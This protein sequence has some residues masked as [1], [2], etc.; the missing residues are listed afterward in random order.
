MLT[1]TGE[2]LQSGKTETPNT[3][4]E[5]LEIFDQW[6]QAHLSK[7]SGIALS[8]PGR[9]DMEN[10]HIH[11]GDALLYLDG[12]N[13]KE[14]FQE[15]YGLPASVV[16]DGKAAGQAELWKGN[17]QGVDYAVSLTLGTGIGGA[18]IVDGKVVQGTDFLAGELSSLYLDIG[19][20]QLVSTFGVK[21]S[22][23][24]FIKRKARLLG[25]ADDTDGRAVFEA[26]VAGENEE[27][28]QKF[29]DY[30]KRIVMVLCNLQITLDISHAVIGGGIS[31]QDILLEEI[32]RQYDKF[33]KNNPGFANIFRPLVID[34]CKYLNSSN[35]IGALYQL[36]L[37]DDR[38]EQ[39]Q[40]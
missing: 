24:Q 30:C 13:V 15:T 22:S 16:N 14:Y 10:G 21:N 11:L 7:I 33:R 2:I 26:I 20:K 18:I 3:F 19:E 35:L 5:L 25:L 12:W 9:I 23:V 37:E 31:E 36:L 28:L 39:A 38:L 17:L 27:L 8:A 40:I 34:K 6:I 1:E 4:K 29:E 32:N